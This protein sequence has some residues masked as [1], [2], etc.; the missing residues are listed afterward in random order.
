MLY[1]FFQKWIE[2]FAYKYANVKKNTFKSI[3]K[4]LEHDDTLAVVLKNLIVFR[5]EYILQF[6]S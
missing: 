3:L 6:G 2:L 1:W 5:I 4:T